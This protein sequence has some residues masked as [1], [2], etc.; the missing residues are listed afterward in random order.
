[1][2][3][4]DLIPGVSGGTLALIT[5]IYEELIHSISGIGV[6][7]LKLLVKG[8]WKA[9]WQ[10]ANGSFLL[11]LLTGIATSLLLLSQGIRKLL[12]LY[13]ILLWAF[14]FGLILASCVMLI[15]QIEGK[16]PR[17]WGAFI[18]GAIIAF[19]ITI[20]NPIQTEIGG[21]YLFICGLLAIVAMILPGIS[22][23]FIL[24]L[25][26]AYEE[27]LKIINQMLHL[28]GIG[29]KKAAILAAGALVGL[30]VFSS[31]LHWILKHHKNRAMAFLTGVMAGS[32]NKVWP[33]KTV[34]QWRTNSEGIQ[35]PL[36]E[37]S[38]WPTAFDGDPQI[39]SAICMA[40]VGAS[41]LYLLHYASKKHQA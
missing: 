33:W 36:I 41:I 32:L 1:M 3:I 39:I 24:L 37:K 30:K 27:A 40:L 14:F 28:D 4:A 6:H 38:V 34:I 13:P 20:I 11:P 19:A 17:L 15:Q 21:L 8:K 12:I 29:F 18:M 2:G 7:T 10:Q 5:G 35:V 23:A 16:H 9:A 26:G 25:L 22:G 31:S